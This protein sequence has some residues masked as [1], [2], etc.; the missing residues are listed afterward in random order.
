MEIDYRYEIVSGVSADRMFAIGIRYDAEY[1]HN[2]TCESW[3]VHIGPDA[4]TRSLGDASRY[5]GLWQ[6][7]DG[8]VVIVHSRGMIFQNPDP[9][10]DPEAWSHQTVD[11]SLTGVW[12]LRS[13]HVWAWAGHDQK[14]YRWEGAAWASV[15][16]PGGWIRAVHGHGD[17]FLFA[18]G[19]D[20]LAMR[21]DG[22]S[23]TKV[24]CGET[25]LTALAVADPDG[26]EIFAAGQ[27][28]GLFEGSSNG[29]SKLLHHD[30]AIL[31]L[32]WWNDEL[33]VGAT[34]GLHKLVNGKLELVKENIVAYALDARGDLV[35]STERFA[36]FSSD[37]VGFTGYTV[38]DFARTRAGA[39]ALWAPEQPIDFD[40]GLP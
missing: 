12:G 24:P 37:G 16:Y 3:C 27:A 28:G 7:P 33:W 15:P 29:L 2:T 35:I 39:P 40:H 26:S 4:V 13:D 18:V 10:A 19:Q 23:W 22:K 36:A 14:L 1:D 38:K 21:W 11:A 25:T 6:A 20:G 32:A 8:R 5:R 34:N 30:S 31:S 9:V 17:H